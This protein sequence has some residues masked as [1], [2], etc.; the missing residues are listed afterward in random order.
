MSSVTPPVRRSL[1]QFL[2]S[3]LSSA[4][5]MPL[6]LAAVDPSPPPNIVFMMSDDQGWGD[7]GY[8]GHPRLETPHTDAMAAQGLRF[9]N[10]FSGAPICSPTR[11]SSLTGRNHNRAGVPAVGGND[12][13]INP[14]ETTFAH[15]LAANGYR[16]GHFG[17]W[18]LKVTLHDSPHRPEQ[19]GFDFYISM[20]NNADKVDPGNKYR[21]MGDTVTTA[22]GES[23]EITMDYA[24][25]F[26]ED[27][28]ADEDPFL[29]VI[30]FN[31]PHTPHGA[32][33][34]DL[35]L[36]D[37]VTDSSKRVYYAMLTAL[38]R[39]V[40][41][42]RSELRR[43]GIEENTLVV[44]C[45]DNGPNVPP[46]ST[47]PWEGKK[48]SL[49][50]GGVRVP[51]I[52][53]WPAVITEP[54]VTEVPMVT[55]DLYPTFLAAA[56]IS[57]YGPPRTID[58]LN[59]M[60]V[61]R[62]EPFTRP[63]NMRFWFGRNTAFV[64]PDGELDRNSSRDPG[65]TAWYNDVMAEAAIANQLVEDTL[66]N[67]LPD[68]DAG[69]DVW[70]VDSDG[71][72]V[73]TTTLDATASSDP[74]GTI[75]RYQWR[76]DGNRVDGAT[77]THDFP[78]G[79]TT[80]RLIVWDDLECIMSDYVTVHVLRPGE[81]DAPWQ[82]IDGQIVVEGEGYHSIDTDGAGFTWRTAPFCPEAVGDRALWL[83]EQGLPY[84]N[85]PT[86]PNTPSVTYRVHSEN[87]GTYSFWLRRYGANSDSQS[88]YV[89]VNGQRQGT[90]SDRDNQTERL[91][92]WVEIDPVQLD[93]GTNLI[94]F[95]WRQCGYYVDRFVLTTDGSWEPEGAGPPATEKVGFDPLP[96]FANYR[97]RFP[98]AQGYRTSPHRDFE[99][100]GLCNILEFAFGF[101]MTVADHRPEEILRATRDNPSRQPVLTTRVL[102][103][104]TG[105]LATGYHAGGL[106]YRLEV[107]G[108]PGDEGW[109]SAE[110]YVVGETSGSLLGDVVPRTVQL[111]LPDGMDRVF[112]RISVAFE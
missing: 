84:N 27:A 94:T 25:S 58:G 44:Y 75:T 31:S 51:G 98:Q 52:I 17:K 93:P 33:P 76:W 87:G 107:N 16:T 54:R 71:N 45:S 47:G 43:M 37:D 65:F 90:F 15:A 6:A 9:D 68:A 8:Y 3:S 91:W 86:N 88:V 39:Q 23:S 35:A 101:D 111:A 77:L 66:A 11:A 5:L 7:V 34:E 59:M 61:L 56:G 72:G 41:R 83:P 10:F 81:R 109:G 108:H 105:D 104:G 1:R 19:L 80:V 22:L 12:G 92:Q 64:T 78:A 38:D 46:G 48:Q 20:N 74:D 70:L 100:D 67:T 53:E 82:E 42:L 97:W 40:G 112:A 103:G 29:A 55:D 106:I 110:A 18:H 2:T 85:Q 79:R 21:Y 102:A 69:P 60:P 50:D 57:E 14:Q 24:L 95:Y 36:Y 96:T 73:E 4:A 63:D 62:D 49:R 32:T 89:Y 30:W 26:I 13:V 99:L 28:V